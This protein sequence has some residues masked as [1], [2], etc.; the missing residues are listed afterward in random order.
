MEA[1][2]IVLRPPI[3]SCG[4]AS[5][6]LELADGALDAVAELVEGRVEGARP[7]HAGALRD[8]RN[9]AACFDGVKDGVAVIGL[10]GDDAGGGEAGDERGSVAGIGGLPASEDEAQRAAVR[11]DGDVPLAGQSPSGTPQSLVAD[12]PFWPVA[13]WAWAR[14]MA[15]SIIR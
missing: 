9:S 6:L 4:D 13:A 8:D 1:G 5:E 2:E 11:I 3:V 14:T 7:G 12:P 10:V 15:L